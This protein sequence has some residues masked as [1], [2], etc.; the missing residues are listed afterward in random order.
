M[1]HRL[2]PPNA[3]LIEWC[4]FMKLSAE[5]TDLLV[6]LID[7][8]SIDHDQLLKGNIDLLCQ[9]L[10]AIYGRTSNQK[11]H[12]LILEIIDK[13]GYSLFGSSFNYTDDSSGS[14]LISADRFYNEGFKMDED[15]FMDLLPVNGYF[16]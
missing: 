2:F 6:K 3:V 16:H 15:E 4:I 13:G 12:E 14:A 9:D 10:L 7:I 5:I 1:R 11:S 8:E